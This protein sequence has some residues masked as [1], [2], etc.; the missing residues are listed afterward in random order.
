[1]FWRTK[2]CSNLPVLL[3]KF[4]FKPTLFSC[5]CFYC[6]QMN[7]RLVNTGRDIRLQIDEPANTHHVNISGGPLSYQYRVS[8]VIIHFGSIASL[9]SEHTVNGHYFPAEVG[10]SLILVWHSLARVDW[11]AGTPGK[12]MVS[13]QGG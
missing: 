10:P 13:S 8:D 6:L 5:H 1:M 3:Y 2:M 4:K 9:G 12:I 11:A 7:G